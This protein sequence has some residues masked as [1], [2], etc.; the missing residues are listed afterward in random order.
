MEVDHLGLHGLSY[1]MSQGHHSQH[2]VINKLIRR[3]L[4]SAKVPSHLEPS[5]TSCVNG[6][7]QV[8]QQWC[9]ASVVGSWHE[10]YMQH[11]LI[12]MPLHI[13][14]LLLGSLVQLQTKQSSQRQ[15]SMLTSVLAKLLLRPGGVWIWGTV[16]AG[17]HWQTN[18]SRDWRATILPVPPPSSFGSH[19]ERERCIGVGHSTPDWQ[20]IYLIPDLLC[21]PWKLLRIS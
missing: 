9:L 10:I 21:L 12:P 7:G 16:P 14:P 17:R 3:P 1:R 15:K 11:V 20:C 5:G 18:Q 4:A 8:G 19:P 6:K 13:W 2:T